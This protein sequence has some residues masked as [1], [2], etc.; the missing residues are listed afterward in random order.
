MPAAKRETAF[1]WFIQLSRVSEVEHQC[2]TM[3]EWKAPEF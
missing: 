3:M 2:T 1:V